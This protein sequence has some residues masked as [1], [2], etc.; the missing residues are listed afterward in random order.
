[1]KSYYLD[2]WDAGAL[3]TVRAYF[4]DCN[5]DA[6]HFLYKFYLTYFDEDKGRWKCKNASACCV[7]LAREFSCQLDHVD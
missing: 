4:G 5:S 7:S 3:N 2:Q 1:M 6:E